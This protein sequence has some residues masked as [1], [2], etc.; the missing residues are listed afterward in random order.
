MIIIE[1]KCVLHMIKIV[2][3]FC[4]TSF[5]LLLIGINK[6][7]FILILVTYLNIS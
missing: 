2:I 6:Q 7:I 1:I 3:K 4:Y 5:G